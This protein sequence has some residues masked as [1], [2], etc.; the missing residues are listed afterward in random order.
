[1]K[2]VGEPQE[3]VGQA[4][5]LFAL[6]RQLEKSLKLAVSRPRGVSACLER[7]GQ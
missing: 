4:E 6:A 5:G 2:V 1:M 7:Y 3:I